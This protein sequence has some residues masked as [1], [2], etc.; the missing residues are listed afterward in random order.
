MKRRKFLCNVLIVFVLLFS[1]VT[2]SIT[3]QADMGPKPA[4]YV[5]IQGIE[6]EYVACFAA[7]SAWGPNYDY[8]RYLAWQE[9]DGYV[10]FEYNPIM[11]Y[12][13]A[14]GFKWIT[15]YYE[16]NGEAKISFTYYCPDE[17][18]IV[19][20]QNGQFLM[21]TEPLQMYAFTTYYKVDFSSATVTTPEQIKVGKNYDYFGEILNLLIRV[22]LTLALEIGLFYLFRLYTKWNFR[23][24]VIINLITQIALNVAVNI[25]QFFSGAL[26]AIFLLFVL[27]FA[28]LMVEFIAY[29]IL[30]KDKKRW[31][32]LLY[33]VL[34]NA[35]SFACGF[36]VFGFM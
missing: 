32:I 6:G 28:I 18:K 15:R 24:V 35:I 25:M 20:Y 8:E 19:V 14:D 36:I 12:H 5:T 26:A 4:S 2:P 21:A 17:Y 7:K 13:D 9:E 33:P 22:V 3:A 11:E 34:A 29:Q 30:F 27:E 10:P 16:C 1:L 23:V 31:K